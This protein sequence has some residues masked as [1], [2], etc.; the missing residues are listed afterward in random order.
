MHF[1]F[2]TAVATLLTVGLIAT[3]IP[4]EHDIQYG[5]AEQ[6]GQLARNIHESSGLAASQI[7][8]EVLWTH[9]DSGDSPTLYALDMEGKK[10]CDCK[11]EGAKHVDWEDMASFRLEGKPHLLI[12]DVGDNGRT[13]KEVH[14]YVVPEPAAN[15]QKATAKRTIRFTYE[16]GPQDCECVAVDPLDSTILLIAKGWTPVLSLIHI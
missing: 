14:L 7:D 13:R 1:R 10:L 15:D 8:Q 12:G 2:E 16:S 4:A 6:L 11:I 9:N 5:S 3:S